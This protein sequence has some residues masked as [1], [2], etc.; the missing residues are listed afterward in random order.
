[1]DEMDLV[2]EI[3]CCACEDEWR[4]GAP[5]PETRDLPMMR[6]RLT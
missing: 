3:G 4:E 1:M 6:Q 5:D 2:V